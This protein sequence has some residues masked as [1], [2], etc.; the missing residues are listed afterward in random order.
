MRSGRCPHQVLRHLPGRASPSVIA[1][2]ASWIAL[3]NGRA[4]D[5]LDGVAERR[6]VVEQDLR[7]LG[8][9]GPTMQWW[10][11]VSSAI[12][13]SSR[14]SIRY[15]SQSGRFGSSGRDSTR[16]TRSCGCSAPPGCGRP[17]RRMWKL[18]SKSA[19]STHTGRASRAPPASRPAGIGARTGSGSQ[20]AR[21]RLH[22]PDLRRER[23]RSGR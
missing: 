15:I 6:L 5:V 16:P 3:G 9:N 10:V 2:K 14:P 21:P 8:R 17:A 1:S 7:E 22:S 12:A 4:S 20:P 11:F 23:Q 13:P 18:M 19:S